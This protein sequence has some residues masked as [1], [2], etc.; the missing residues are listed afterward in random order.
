[1]KNIDGLEYY[2]IAELCDKLNIKNK[3]FYKLKSLNFFGPP[4]SK[5]IDSRG[6]NY[7]GPFYPKKTLLIAIKIKE[8]RD[9]SLSY[10]EIK[11]NIFRYIQD[12]KEEVQ[13]RERF[14]KYREEELRIKDNYLSYLKEDLGKDEVLVKIV[15][16][17]IVS[18]KKMQE[19]LKRHDHYIKRLRTRMDNENEVVEEDAER[20]RH[21]QEDM[22]LIMRL[23]NRIKVL[24]GLEKQ[25]K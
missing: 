13:E 1:M 24:E 8:L 18:K 11:D 21:D 20:D 7:R 5:L 2:N 22:E 15:D 23:N 12:G 9:T 19:A 14:F 3:M 16:D 10:T 17:K 4:L 25:L 6:K